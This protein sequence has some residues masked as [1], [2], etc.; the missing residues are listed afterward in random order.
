M[1]PDNL[2]TKIHALGSDLSLWSCRKVI[3][4]MSGSRNEEL[5][6]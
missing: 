5:V 6:G 4:E 1:R 2:V 3:G